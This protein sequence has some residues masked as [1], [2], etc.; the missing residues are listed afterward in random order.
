MAPFGLEH[1]TTNVLLP[2]IKM[3]VFVKPLSWNKFESLTPLRKI[4]Q[5]ILI[6]VLN[7]KGFL[8]TEADNII[9]CR[10]WT[11]LRLHQNRGLR[12]TT[13]L[14]IIHGRHPLPR[15]EWILK[16]LCCQGDPVHTCMTLRGQDLPADRESQ[17]DR[18]ASAAP[19]RS[20]NSSPRNRSGRTV[21]SKHC[22]QTAGRTS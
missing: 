15:P 10:I 21:N 22:K 20:G 13:T 14:L 16:A 1:F 6:S 18:P 5:H 12:L 3:T 17:P 2:I 19:G 9:W 11:L 8:T 7:L 4:L